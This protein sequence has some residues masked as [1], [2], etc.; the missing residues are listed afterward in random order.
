M[1]ASITCRNSKQEL[2]FH[3]G[4]PVATRASGERAR[5]RREHAVTSPPHPFN[6]GGN[7]RGDLRVATEEGALYLSLVFLLHLVE[8]PPPTK[9]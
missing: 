9:A 6:P 5:E 7:R 3:L 8:S 1:I 2:H 4:I